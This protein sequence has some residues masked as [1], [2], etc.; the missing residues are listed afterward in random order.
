MNSIGQLQ[1]VCQKRHIGI[2]TYQSRSSGPC[3]QPTFTVTCYVKEF[4]E[5]SASASKLQDAKMAAAAK[6]LEKALPTIYYNMT[7]S[8][9]T[10]VTANVSIPV[11]VPVFVNPL[12]PVQIHSVSSSVLQSPV[13]TVHE[14]NQYDDEDNGPKRKDRGTQ[15]DVIAKVDADDGIRK[16]YKRMSDKRIQMQNLLA[17]LIDCDDDMHVVEKIAQDFCE[18]FGTTVE[19]HNHSEGSGYMSFF[20][21][22]SEDTVVALGYGSSV[23]S[24]DDAMSR[25]I[26]RTLNTF[27][28]SIP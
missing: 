19:L 22:R 18:A 2:P 7:N 24:R 23:I 5:A 8:M 16:F 20:Y 17:P 10:S 3:H 27:A 1:E 28:A 6:L 9:Q 25:A 14:D 4:G 12:P 21:L 11:R 26:R 13:K 15:F